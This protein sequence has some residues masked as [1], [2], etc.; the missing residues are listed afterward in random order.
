MHNDQNSILMFPVGF[1]LCEANEKS[2]NKALEV[3]QFAV[4][5]GIWHLCLV[6]INH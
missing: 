5:V 2:K 4:F 6:V 3:R 1:R